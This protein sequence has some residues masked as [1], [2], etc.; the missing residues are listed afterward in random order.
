MELTICFYAFRTSGYA[1]CRMLGCV[2]PAMNLLGRSCSSDKGTRSEQAAPPTAAGRP[3]LIYTTRFKPKDTCRRVVSAQ[4]YARWCKEREVSGLERSSRPQRRSR[5]GSGFIQNHDIV[6]ELRGRETP[7][8]WR[9][10]LTLLSHEHIDD[11]WVTYT[12][13]TRRSR[14][15]GREKRDKR[16][17]EQRLEICRQGRNAIP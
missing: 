15:G 7:M 12:A 2:K 4:R 5:C 13:A 11:C 6:D 8:G 10:S 1:P 14:R 17:R 9:V 16:A 3:R